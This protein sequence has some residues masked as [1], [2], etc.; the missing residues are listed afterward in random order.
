MPSNPMKIL[1]PASLMLGLA[2]AA[3]AQSLPDPQLVVRQY[4]EY[5]EIQAL[6]TRCDWFG[7]LESQALK[8][9]LRERKAWL[10]VHGGDPKQAEAEAGKRV[11]AIAD[12]P[13][14]GSQADLRKHE[15]KQLVWQTT[16]AWTLR[17]EALLAGAERP[18]W[19]KGQSKVEAHR[20]ALERRAGELEA[21]FASSMEVA[22]PRI[23]AD[24]ERMLRL[25]CKP[26]PGAGA[27]CPAVG[28]EDARL[29]DYAATWVAETEAFAAVL[30]TAP[31]VPTPSLDAPGA[32]EPAP[33]KK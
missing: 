33:A 19:Y 32:A 20:A 22:R 26:K 21:E 25:V 10:A 29:R 28:A 8:S 6:G 27:S 12:F 13:C 4:A 7:A 16:L 23:Q 9:T 31:P 11:A 18:A 15:I 2:G 5:S 24:A 1:F 3:T 17:G 14:A 30:E